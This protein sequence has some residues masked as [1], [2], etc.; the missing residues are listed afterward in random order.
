MPRT[1]FCTRIQ[2]SGDLQQREVYNSAQRNRARRLKARRAPKQECLSFTNVMPGDASQ[3]V[4]V[5]IAVDGVHG[6][7]PLLE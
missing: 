4:A 2:R 7:L 1:N 6:V 5:T 3:F